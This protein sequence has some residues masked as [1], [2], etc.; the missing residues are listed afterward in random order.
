LK[1]AATSVAALTARSALPARLETG[2]AVATTAET[3]LAPRTTAKFASAA[4][5]VPGT[6]IA[7][8]ATGRRIGWSCTRLIAGATRRTPESPAVTP[9]GHASRAITAIFATRTITAAFTV[10]T[11]ACGRLL[12]G[13]LRAEA[14]ALKL[15][16]IEFIEIRRRILLGSVVV[17]V[18]RVKRVCYPRGWLGIKCALVSG[19]SVGGTATVASSFPAHAARAL[20]V[21]ERARCRPNPA[22]SVQGS[23]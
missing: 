3:A 10:A 13:P 2:T 22:G 5:F 17:H 18:V 20:Q 15:A 11:V 1:R 4:T 19:R 7:A 9:I 12:L 23:K 8:R 6:A 16:Q 21:P 14:E